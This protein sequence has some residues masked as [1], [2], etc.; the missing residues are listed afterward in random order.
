MYDLQRFL[1]AQEQNY[2]DALA[3]LKAGRKTTHWIWYVMPQMRG[4]GR[5]EMA[6]KFGIVDLGE[7]QAYLAHP[8]LGAR[9]LDCCRALLNHTDKTAVEIL[10]EIDAVKVRSCATLFREAGGAKEFSDIL[11]AFYDGEP[12]PLTLDLLENA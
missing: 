12:D 6:R 2:D 9:L 4:L 11:D 10:G 7:A 3:E 8:I 1:D 5:T